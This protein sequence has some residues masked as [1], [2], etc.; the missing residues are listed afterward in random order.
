MWCVECRPRDGE[1]HDFIVCAN[2]DHCHRAVVCSYSGFLSYVLDCMSFS[3][4]SVPYISMHLVSLSVSLPESVK[5]GLFL[6]Q[7]LSFVDESLWWWSTP[8]LLLSLESTLKHFMIHRSDS[9]V[10]L[11]ACGCAWDWSACGERDTSIMR[12]SQVWF[13][14]ASVSCQSLMMR[15]N[16][17]FDSYHSLISV[18]SFYIW[19]SG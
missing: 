13:W 6:S 15:L 19:I 9:C 10:S 2:R 7:P 17:H 14:R 18:H 11:D 5:S 3:I 4:L 8:L 12:R 1:L 16:W